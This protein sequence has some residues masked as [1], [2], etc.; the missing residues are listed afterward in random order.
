MVRR[1]L[2]LGLSTSTPRG[3]VALA[4]EEGVLA[5]SDYLE[6][7]AHAGRLMLAVD[8]LFRAAGV[9]RS[10]LGAVA[11]DLGPGSFTGIRIAVA[12]ANGI[13]LAL[14]VPTFG[15]P[16]LEAMARGARSRRPDAEILAALDAQK[17]EIYL[18]LSRPSSPM[19][20]ACAPKAVAIERLH[21]ASARG[22]VVVGD[23]LDRLGV[24]P[25]LRGAPVELPDASVLAY[26]VAREATAA[27]PLAGA[28][29]QPF[30]VRAP[31]AKPRP[32]LAP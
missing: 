13:A 20:I 10:V 22:A 31:D 16:S 23:V 7:R 5:A 19:E 8:E 28:A 3:S 21:E 2:V 12:A 29:L 30:Y 15:M 9:D 25:T 4:S 32:I 27:P 17:D 11:C 14:C 18:G 24:E 1:V 6:L 26:A